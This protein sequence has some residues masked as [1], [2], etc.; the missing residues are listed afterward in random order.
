M[1]RT[2]GDLARRRALAD[3]ASGYPARATVVLYACITHGQDQRAVFA[4]LRR[5]AE[6]RDWVV[7]GEVTDSTAAT[8]PLQDRPGW[9]AAATA[10]TSGRASGIV[11]AACTE[12]PDIEPV[13][14]WL[15]EHRA[16]LSQV[17]LTPATTRG[18]A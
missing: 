17:T 16:F 3:A 5:H 7:I 9:P 12:T 11:V 13:G 6:A 15:D 10:I 1:T 4:Q 2:P 14:A 8:I 18:A